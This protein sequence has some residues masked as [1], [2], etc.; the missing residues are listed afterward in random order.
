MASPRGVLSS[1]I[2]YY[3]TARPHQGL[4]QHLPISVPTSARMSVVCRR[5]M[6]GG[7]VHD[8]YRE[9]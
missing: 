8:F 3:S 2:A 6:L 7:I 1:Y 5:P 9:A 4:E